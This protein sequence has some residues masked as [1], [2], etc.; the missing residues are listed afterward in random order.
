MG[1]YPRLSAAAEALPP[2]IYA[3]LYQRLERFE[4]DTIRFSI[5]DTHLAP[6][7]LARLGALDFSVAADPLLYA[8]SAPRGDSDL[9]DALVAKLGAQNGL[10]V[11]A[12]NVQIT[13]GATHALSCAIRAVLDPGDELLVLAPYWPLIRNIALASSVRP[14]EVPFSHRLLRD[15]SCDPT[16]LIEPFMTPRTAAI[17]V[18]TPNNPDGMIMGPRELQA[19]AAIAKRYDVWVIADEV[20]EEFGYDAAHLSI[21]SLPGM[22]ERTMTAF[23]FSKSFALAGLRVGY[24]VGPRPAIAAV[25]NMANTSVYCVSRA[26]QRAALAALTTGA[27]FLAQARAL[28]RRHR[29]LAVAGLELRCRVPQAGTYLFLDLSEHTRQD[30]PCCIQLLERFAD[31]GVLLTPGAAFGSMCGKWCRLCYTAVDSARLEEGIERLN[32]VLA[33][34]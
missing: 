30:D 13:N 25:R 1:K 14:V 29:D 22:G 33:S 12:E 3:R 21:A 9:L 20:Y 15:P 16:A 11:A 8:Y 27:G 26:M 2:S 19:I 31:A 28:Y 34:G 32:R 10:E 4:G 24:A 5:G 7:E 23:S 6:P 17:Y 18:S